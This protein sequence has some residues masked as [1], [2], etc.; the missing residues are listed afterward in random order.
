MPWS[1]AP[2]SERAGRST[3]ETR[4]RTLA[5]LLIRRRGV[6]TLAALALLVLSARSLPHLTFDLSV[7]PLLEASKEQ[8][9][10]IVAFSEELPPENYDVLV[11]VEWPRVLVREDLDRL[12]GLEQAVKAWPDVD[13][14]LSLGTLSVIEVRGGSPR[15]SLPG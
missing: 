1:T 5:A 10:E 7:T 13:V 8:Q 9:A 11:V 12:H 2:G 6:F 14:V 4:L 15:P 3:G